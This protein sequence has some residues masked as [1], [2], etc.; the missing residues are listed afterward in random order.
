MKKWY[1]KTGPEQA[2]VVSSCI[3]LSRNLRGVPFPD[4]LDAEGKR[5]VAKKL[6][7]AVFRENG[8]IARDFQFTDLEPLRTIEAVALTERGVLKADFIENREG[9]CLLNSPDESRTI[10][11]NGEDHF[12]LQVRKPGLSLQ[13]AYSAADELDTFLDNSLHFAFDGKLGYL[14][15]NPAILGT[16]MLASLDLHLPALADTGATTRIAANLHTLGLSLSSA[17][18]LHG[19]LFRLTNRMTLGLSEQDAV[20]N[21]CGIARQIIAQEYEA[22]KKLIRNIS[23]QDTV[24]RSLGIFRSARLLDYDELLDLASVI[25]FGVATGF[26]KSVR[27][28]DIDS[29]VVRVQPACLALE[30]GMG[31]TEDE[32]RAM[33]A[34]I[35]REVFSAKASAGEDG[36]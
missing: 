16:G 9:R 8:A 12:L 10:L 29:I 5:A 33:R 14:T 32:E 27:M 7:D 19:S 34:T 26:E 13:E 3:R 31:L 35:V 30:A 23:V 1:E 36:R 6:H 21:L 18:H 4:L 17:P 22:R 11:A 15:A 2:A 25:R 28:E 24:E 20:N